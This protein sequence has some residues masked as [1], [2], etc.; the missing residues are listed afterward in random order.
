VK[1]IAIGVL[2][3]RVTKHG[4]NAKELMPS[5]VALRSLAVK[6]PGYVKMA[7]NGYVAPKR[8]PMEQLVLFVIL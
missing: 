5:I 6:Q 1:N 2:I 3:K 4:V 8:G 7:T